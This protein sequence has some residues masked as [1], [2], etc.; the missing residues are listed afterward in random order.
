MN[1]TTEELQQGGRI[2]VFRDG[3]QTVPAGMFNGRNIVK[4]SFKLQWI[5][6]GDET[7]DAVTAEYFSARS[8]RT[9]EVTARVRDEAYTA[10]LAAE[11]KTD[12]QAVREEWAALAEKPARIQL[13][14]VTDRTHA[15]EEADYAAADNRYR[16]RLATFNTEMDGMIPTYGDLVAV[17]HDMPRWGQGGNLIDWTADDIEGG[18]PYANA[19]LTLSEPP[20]WTEA[21]T[22]YIVLRR[23]DGS[24]VGPFEATPGPSADQVTLAEPLT[25]TPYVGGS[26]ERTYYSFGAGDEWARFCLVRALRPRNA[27]EQVEMAVVAEDDRVHVN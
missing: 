7:A 17:A 23:R 20:E 22:H 5:M 12:S 21:A 11:S 19:V 27:G 8:W 15:Y 4:G 18:A 9:A 2:R 14:G 25:V 10:W 3:P 6:P 24:L 16:R 26:E 1:A 13:F